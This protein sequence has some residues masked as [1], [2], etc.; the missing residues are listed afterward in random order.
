M[1]Y[2]ILFISLFCWFVT[3]AQ[4]TEPCDAVKNSKKPLT[5]CDKIRCLYENQK[6]IDA[7]VL[8]LQAGKNCTEIED[9]IL[10]A[11]IAAANNAFQE[12]Q[13]ILEQL[14]QHKEKEE[15]IQTEIRRLTQLS[16]M[17]DKE[18]GTYIQNAIKLNTVYNDLPAFALGDTLYPLYDKPDT[19]NY[20]PIIEE[21]PR[22]RY[23]PKDV[24]EQLNFGDAYFGWKKFADLSSGVVYKDS[25]L[26]LTILSN[27]AYSTKKNYEIICLDLHAKREIKRLGISI[28]GANVMHPAIK[29]SILFFSSDMPGGYGN[30]DLY[31]TIIR[32]RGF[33]EFEN[34]GPEI[35]TKDNEIFAAIA[36]DTLFFSSD[37]LSGFGGLDL[38]KTHLDN[39]KAINIGPPVN[40]PYDD[41]AATSVNDKIKYF[42][43]NRAGGKGQNDIYHVSFVEPS[44][45]FQNLTGKIQVKNND[46]LSTI[47]VRI[48]NSDGS[49]SQTTTLKSDGS[50]T[51][52]HI[53]GL[54]S[55]E[56]SVEGQE[57]PDDTRMAIFGQEG[58]VIKDIPVSKGGI[59]K[60]ELLTPLDYYL[61]RIE[62]E[63]KSVLTVDILGLIESDEHLEEGFRIYLEDSDGKLIGTA[64]TDKDGNFIFKAVKPDEKYVI[65]SQVTDPNA[66]IHILT[67]EG[68]VLSSIKPQA[69]NDFVYV[70]L[71]D[72]DRVIT[73][74]NEF[75]QKI[76][77]ADNELFNL[78]VLYFG[79]NEFELND[80]SKANLNKLVVLLEKNPTINLEL[81]G[82]TD[83]RG[84]DNY[85]FKL[86][87]KRI[88]TV[89]KYLTDHGIDETRLIGRGYGESKLL[90][91]CA[92]GVAC[93]EEEHA[94]NRRT[95]IRIYQEK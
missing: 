41:Y 29:D 69:G 55:Y 65:K 25:L 21:A 60:F 10:F 82:H 37:R 28:K 59:F 48:Q 32:H 83:S 39:L 16:A 88:K 70:R 90:N 33:S 95:E 85:N 58:N 89:I 27:N 77:V 6:I 3:K 31:K 36:G 4:N 44:V 74:T 61:E 56:I 50:F 35:N 49:Y 26:F 78:E 73:L 80:I 62:N 42:A 19:I 38:Y 2:L 81:S 51:F 94:I 34:L 92:D 64:T 23:F 57:I 72:A 75:E 20:F 76:K 24:N 47:V 15:L 1:R 22:L 79:L 14:S 5:F 17:M 66:T 12:A 68:E 93:T 9:Q 67:K 40:T 13:N 7:Y 11:R 30:A 53:K 52:A 71:S 46:D 43:S 45:F 8:S 87:H 18:S 54:E 91:H 63:D 86:S 84:S